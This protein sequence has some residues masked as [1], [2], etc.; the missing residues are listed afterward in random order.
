MNTITGDAPL[1]HHAVHFENHYRSAASRFLVGHVELDESWK[2]FARSREAA[3]GRRTGRSKLDAGEIDTLESPDPESFAEA[4]EAGLASIN[5]TADLPSAFDSQILLCRGAA[6]HNDLHGWDN[7]LFLNWYLGGVPRDFVIAGVGRLTIRPGD[8]ILFD[9][10][11]P[12]GL[13]L[14]GAKG[15]SRTGWGSAP[16]DH[17]IFLSCDIALTPALDTLF[18]IERGTDAM[19]KERSSVDIDNLKI[20]RT[21][22]NLRKQSMLKRAA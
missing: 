14:E 4:A 22:G 7:A 3:V 12:H 10:S 5:V 1:F 13:V 11:R 6:F 18:G 15:F 16:E 2:E 17:S 8:V 21:S 19:F 20:V 9:P